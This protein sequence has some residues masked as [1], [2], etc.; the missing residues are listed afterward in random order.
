MYRTPPHRRP[1]HLVVMVALFAPL[2]LVGALLPNIGQLSAVARNTKPLRLTSPKRPVSFTSP[3]AI[4]PVLTGTNITLQATEADIPI[5]SGTPTRMWTYN[6]MFPGPTIHQTSGQTTRL[7]LVNNLPAAGSLSLHHHGSHST[8]ESDGQPESYL[9]APGA[10]YTYVYTGTE[11]GANERGAMHWYHDHRMDMTGHN[12]WMGLAGMYIIDD[13]ADPQ[14]LPSGQFDVPLMVMDRAFDANNQLV[15]TFDQNGVQGDQMLVNGVI[16]PY[17]EVADRKY[18]LRVLNASN[19]SDI[20]LALSNGQPIVQVGTESGL[21]P[22]PVSRQHI[23]LGPAE[24]ADI[25]VDFAGLLDQNITLLNLAG[26][27][28]TSEI[29]QFRV[30]SHVTDDSSVPSTL[31]PLPDLGTPVVTRTF[32]FGHTDGHWTING[33]TYDPNRVDAQPVLGTTER[34]I[35]Q[36]TTGEWHHVIHIHL[37]NHQII[38]RNGVPAEPYEAMKESWYLNP[39]DTVELLIKF[40]DYT[41]LYVFH[42][43]LLEHED[44]SMMGQ[45]EVVAATPTTTPTETTTNT[46]TNTLT[47]TYTRTPT[48]LPTGVPTDTSTGTST[49]TFT[50]TN[51]PTVTRTSTPSPTCPPGTPTTTSVSIVNFAFNPQ[52]VTINQGSTVR[53]TNTTGGTTHTSASNTNVWNSG[54]ITP[55][56]SFSFTFNTPGAYPY[57]CNIHPNMT[58]TVNVVAPVCA[59]NTPTLTA[60][61]T[62]TGTPTST[63]TR[64]STPTFT[65]TPTSTPTFTY[66]STNTPTSSN[67]NTPTNTPISTSTPGT[68]VLLVGHVTWQGRTVGSSAYRVPISLTLK[69]GT[70]ESDYPAQNTDASGYFTVT[71]EGLAAGTYDYRVKDPKYLA[72]AGQVALTGATTTQVEMGQQRAGD[73]NNDNVVNVSDFNILRGTFGK[74]CSDAGYDDRPDFNGDCNVSVGDFNLL[75]GNFGVA[76]AAALRSA[77]N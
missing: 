16:Q 56:Q 13:P 4:P 65:Y 28:S 77:R 17:F 7:T 53:W 40:T 38:S 42:C 32:A 51:T 57:H 33:L 58:G 20:D 55:G 1:S 67:T 47:P 14:T 30:N 26:Q 62:F 69:L 21:L 29:M 64:T 3:L 68:V 27:Q 60:V 48:S 35:L 52:T 10:S 45:F 2:M 44:D 25:I 76:G 31:R 15:Y 63:N 8:G 18:R 50:R 66:T 46:P 70:A 5:M 41:G 19:F 75:R 22:A 34:W 72:S 54:N 6:G 36:N 74:A 59:T 9:V 24:R 73:A 71:V 39:G 23:L 37:T 11:D 61:P 43:H 12:V 49:Q